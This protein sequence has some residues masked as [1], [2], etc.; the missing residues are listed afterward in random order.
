MPKAR[1]HLCRKWEGDVFESGRKRAA[2]YVLQFHADGR[3]LSGLALKTSSPPSPPQLPLVQMHCF[4][5]VYGFSDAYLNK[6]RHGCVADIAT[7]CNL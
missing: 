3:A 1:V 7:C 4:L 5:R 6:P 2:V